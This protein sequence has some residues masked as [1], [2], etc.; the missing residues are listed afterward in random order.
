MRPNKPG[1]LDKKHPEAARDAMDDIKDIAGE[2]HLLAVNAGIL[3]AGIAVL[4]CAH[5]LP[6]LF[7]TED[8]VVVRTGDLTLVLPRARAAD[9]KTL[10]KELFQLDHQ[11]KL[12]P[13]GVF[14][15]QID[16]RVAGGSRASEGIKNNVALIWI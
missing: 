7:G 5:Y 14:A 4:I 9:L 1:K 11:N 15:V 6:L 12:A 16:N 8:L 2:I 10:L 13:P 3:T